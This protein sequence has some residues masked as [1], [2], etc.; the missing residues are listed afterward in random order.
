MNELAAVIPFRAR[1]GSGEDVARL[2][3]GALPHVESEAGTTTWLVLRS[4][5]DP[6]LI[7]L[8]DL[9]TDHESRNAHMSGE[10]AKLIFASVPPL[11]AEPPSIHPAT[12]VARKP[13]PGKGRM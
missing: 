1:T 9:F 11:L 6:D 8:I 13:A 5:A 10:A 12:I 7:F 4:E 3:A 2:I